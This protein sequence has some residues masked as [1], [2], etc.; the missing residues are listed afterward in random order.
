[1][2]QD[3][4]SEGADGIT[5]KLTRPVEMNGVKQNQIT[6]RVPTVGDL[7]AAERQSKDDKESREIML[8]A[9]LANC[10]PADIERL[11]VKDYGRIQ[12]CYFRLISDG[13]GP[14]SESDR[15]APGL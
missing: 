10:A 12:D 6:V 9:T 4:M 11:T 13:D 7:R 15:A 14:G 5:V 2:N 1:M 3:W 8:F